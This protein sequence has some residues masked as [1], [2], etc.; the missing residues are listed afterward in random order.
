M[1]FNLVEELAEVITKEE[2]QE[3]DG[4]C[5]GCPFYSVTDDDECCSELSLTQKLLPIISAFL[6]SV[7]NP[8]K[9]RADKDF[10]SGYLHSKAMY[11]EGAFNEAIA[12]L[13]AALRDKH[14]TE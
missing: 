7:E 12:A 8:Y 13:K 6:D 10:V 14:G 11:K 9:K 4:E 2:Q 3:C 5:A 1:E